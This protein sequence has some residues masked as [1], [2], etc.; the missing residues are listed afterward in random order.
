MKTY[1]IGLIRGTGNCKCWANGHNKS[2][3]I[4]Q[5]RRNKDYLSPSLWQYYGERETTKKRLNELK[6]VALQAINKEHGTA[7]TSIIID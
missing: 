2:T 1:F 7:F 5:A 6:L 3:V 4:I